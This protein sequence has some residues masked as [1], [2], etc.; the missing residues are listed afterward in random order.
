VNSAAE[1]RASDSPPLPVAA[2]AI[3]RLVGIHRSL[4]NDGR[5]KPGGPGAT[6]ASEETSDDDQG[7]EPPR[8]LDYAQT[9][10]RSL[11][12]ILPVAGPVPVEPLGIADVDSGIPLA[13]AHRAP[14]AALAPSDAPDSAQAPASILDYAGPRPRGKDGLANTRLPAVSDLRLDFEPDGGVTI[15]E[16]LAGKE[17]AIIAI[18]FA[19]VIL[20]LV[21]CTAIILVKEQKPPDYAGASVLAVVFVVE[22]V[23]LIM[24]ISNT[25]RRTV[26]QAGPAGLRLDFHVL[27]RRP[28]RH[29]WPADRV[30]KMGILPQPGPRG[31]SEAASPAELRIEIKDGPRLHL[32]TGHPKAELWPLA[33]HIE[34]GLG[35]ERGRQDDKVTR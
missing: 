28:K 12:R 35:G 34:R 29:H 18:A 22:L 9:P 27:L 1:P 20:V 10:K 11:R 30:R 2:A 6:D 15:T 23:V 24:V 21:A 19:A 5:L 31:L 26:V 13:T 25:W 17:M 16:T 3:D 7:D 4:W 33:Q 8:T 32:F 14:L